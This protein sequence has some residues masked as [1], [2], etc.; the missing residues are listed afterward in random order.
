M[1]IISNYFGNSSCYN[2]KPYGILKKIYVES[3]YGLLYIN[4]MGFNPESWHGLEY[5]TKTYLKY[6]KYKLKKG[7]KKIPDYFYLYKNK[8]K[9]R[10]EKITLYF[11]KLFMKFIIKY[12][13]LRLNSLLLCSNYKNFNDRLML[14]KKN[15]KY[16]CKGKS[17]NDIKILKFILFNDEIPENMKFNDKISFYDNIYVNLMKC[18]K[19][20]KVKLLYENNV[21]FG[22]R[23][24]PKRGIRHS[25]NLIYAIYHNNFEAVKYLLQ[26]K[27]KLGYAAF[28]AM[29]KHNR[30]D[31]I[32]Y[33]MDNY[34]K[35]CHADY[36]CSS[37]IIHKIIKNE[38]LHLFEKYY[39]ETE[40]IIVHICSFII[41]HDKIKYTNYVDK[42]YIK[43]EDEIAKNVSSILHQQCIPSEI[44]DYKFKVINYIYDNISKK[45]AVIQHYRPFFTYKNS[46]LS[47]LFENNI[48]RI[49]LYNKCALANL[50]IEYGI[51]NGYLEQVKMLHDPKRYVLD[52][53]C[54]NILCASKKQNDNDLLKTLKNCRN[55]C[56]LDGSCNIILKSLRT[57]KRQN[58][59]LKTLEYCIQ[60]DNLADKNKIIYKLKQF[61]SI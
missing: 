38:L 57:S 11:Y 21:S 53:S 3:F 7:N 42:Y 31:I 58:D 46:G 19:F 33:I 4:S 34:S 17:D 26:R 22:L 6:L 2:Y 24:K 12:Y 30:Q 41:H 1:Y 39:R 43:Y 16:V 27:C 18:N 13:N 20:E 51:A 54:N 15:F 59:L 25:Q 50:T 40:W 47:K 36:F 14:I 5:N 37:Y 32:K 28:F 56:I 8:I 23:S 49:I 60:Y 10:N 48:I 61:I 52:C 45:M 35:Y 44:K 55:S 9:K 29:I